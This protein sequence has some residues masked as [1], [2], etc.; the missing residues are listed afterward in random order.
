MIDKRLITLILI[1]TFVANVQAFT[2]DVEYNSAIGECTGKGTQC[3]PNG[4]LLY[5]CINNNFTST[6][7][8]EGTKCLAIGST[9]A[10]RED[11]N[12]FTKQDK[13]QLIIG[14]AVLLVIFAVV[15]LILKN[16]IKK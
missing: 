3:S 2:F 6:Q 13:N 1:F 4:K 10:C 7:C 14:I 16:K 9:A 15:W 5:T 12:A 8:A 11:P